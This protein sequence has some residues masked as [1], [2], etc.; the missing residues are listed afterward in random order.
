MK[1]I[2]TNFID[3]Y[4]ISN[5]KLSARNFITNILLTFFYK[6]SMK[7]Y[8]FKFTRTLWRPCIIDQCK[9]IKKGTIG[10]KIDR[11]K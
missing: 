4:S 11:E 9:T 3:I 1:I 10:I 5:I 6:D 2:V 7:S 8:K